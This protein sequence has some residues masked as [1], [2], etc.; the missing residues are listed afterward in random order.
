MGKLTG[1][2]EYGRE[3]NAERSSAERIGDFQ[4][5]HASLPEETRRRQAARCM[6][7]GVP[8]CQTGMIL[9]GMATGCP[10]HNL[11]P[12]YNDQ[13][14]A[15]HDRYGLARLLKTNNFPEFTGRVCPALC[16]AAC[17]NGEHGEAVTC[18][19][20]ELFLIEE[21]FAR[22]WMTPRIPAV[23][24]GK[25]AAV[26][27]AG[28]AGL[29][30]ADQLNHRGHSV[31][32]FEKEDRIGGL[33]MYG[34]PNMKLD[35]SVLHRRQELMEAEGVVF[36][37]GVEVGKDVSAAELLQEYD[38]V[39]LCGGARQARPLTAVNNKDT[40]GIVYAVDFLSEVTRS[41]LSSPAG[42]PHVEGIRGRN[43]IVVGGGDTGNDCIATLVRL[44]AG[45]VTALEMMPRPPR[46]RAEDNPWPEWPRVE[47]VD[48]GHAE[49][50]LRYGWDPRIYSTTVKEVLRNDQQ[51]ITG[52]RTVQVVMEKGQMKEV[53][54]TEETRR[55][56]LLVIAAGFT[57]CRP[58]LPGAFGLT[59][60]PRHTVA[61]RPGHFQTDNPRVFTAGDM[62]RGPSLV[63][64]AIAE[65]RLAA[66][67]A[68]AWL[69]GYTNA[70]Y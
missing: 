53:A 6:N 50:I 68:D 8:L 28:P 40:Q 35:K 52:V 60:G 69:M 65:G 19:D 54:G 5:F 46:T 42:R 45:S 4:E 39:L 32:V 16:E 9:H 47:K 2:L 56:D 44:G 64:W 49:A 29:A 25:K 41:L 17:L 70:G 51:R 38:V 33:L 27:G 30:A 12:E 67:E 21:A 10:L 7:C 1:F 18:R 22:G 59:L 37:T 20:N 62:H 31:T 14:Y 11:I 48:Y 63:V 13:I 43:V 36:R 55:C 58:Q 57:G 15:G 61:T 24:S 26:I 23:R 3:M 34:I 66:R